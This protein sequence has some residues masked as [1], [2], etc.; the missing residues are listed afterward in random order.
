MLVNSIE[1]LSS[2]FDDIAANQFIINANGIQGKSAAFKRL[3]G[4]SKCDVLLLLQEYGTG[5]EQV[6]I[7]MM[8]QEHYPN[9]G[10][11][12]GAEIKNKH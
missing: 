7:G 9:A 10:C 1:L 8:S 2:N 6:P 11:G 3:A 5:K 12:C 4:Y